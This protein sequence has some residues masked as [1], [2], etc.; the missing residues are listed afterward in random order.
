MA[1]LERSGAKA[2]TARIEILMLK[3]ILGDV[4]EGIKIRRKN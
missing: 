2:M 1:A 3:S 4:S